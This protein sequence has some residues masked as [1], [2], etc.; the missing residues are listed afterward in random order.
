MFRNTVSKAGYSIILHIRQ[1]CLCVLLYLFCV[2]SSNY[3]DVETKISVV[4][5]RGEKKQEALETL[6]TLQIIENLV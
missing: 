5:E 6:C 1:Q 3:N 2:T 4:L